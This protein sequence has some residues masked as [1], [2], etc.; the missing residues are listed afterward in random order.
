MSGIDFGQLRNMVV[1]PVL[2]GLGMNSDAA[3]D[4]VVGTAAQESGGGRWIRQVAAGGRQG[5]ARGLW[6]M[7]P[8]THADIENRYLRARPELAVRV[9]GFAAPL[10]PRVDQ[11]HGNL[12]YACAMARLRYWMVPE[13]L[14]ETGDVDGYARYWKAHY[15]TPAGAG[16]PEDFVAS[17]RA[18]VEE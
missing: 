4:L 6:Q 10:P 1:R 5:V 2:V 15:N 17:W 3:E 11:L 7:E 16:T 9:F 14:P 18:Y 13:P 12:Y 8:A